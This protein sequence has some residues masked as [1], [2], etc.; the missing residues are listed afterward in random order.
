ML[1]IHRPDGTLLYELYNWDGPLVGLDNLRLVSDSAIRR[2]KFD[3]DGNL[4]LYAW[5]D[6]G[7][8]VLT[9]EPF[10]LRRPTPRLDG[11]GMSAW[12]AGVLSCAYLIKLDPAT[13]RVI[14]GTL[15]LAYLK[16]RDKPNSIWVDT[17]GFAADGSVC[18]GGKSAWGLIQTGN[19]LHRGEPTGPYVAVFSRDFTSLRFSSTLPGTGAVD[20]RDGERWGVV[21]GRPNGRPRVLFVGGA[22]DGAPIAGGPQPRFGGGHADGYLLLLDLSR[23]EK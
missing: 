20:L 11:L 3:A 17:L 4:L 8:S 7:N 14:G 18:V 13:L 15:W 21:T 16:D 6:G 23:P 10:D 2:V 12:G 1:N 9:R 19:A 22:V 5:S